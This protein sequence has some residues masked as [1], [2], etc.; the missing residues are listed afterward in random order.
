MYVPIRWMSH[1]LCTE[2]EPVRDLGPPPF[3]SNVLTSV[4]TEPTGL[5][6]P[7]SAEWVKLRMMSPM[8]I[9]VPRHSFLSACVYQCKRFIDPDDRLAQPVGCGLAGL[10]WR[11]L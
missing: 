5:A 2:H 8:K 10:E 11:L 3:R 9:F 7:R 4:H 1:S 6:L